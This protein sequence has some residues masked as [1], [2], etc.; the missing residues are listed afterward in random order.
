MLI[1]LICIPVINT[2]VN[3]ASSTVLAIFIGGFALNQLWLFW[4]E[5]IV[6]DILADFVYNFIH[7]KLK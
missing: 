2:S 1:Y 7:G 6:G 5:S 3:S 4:V